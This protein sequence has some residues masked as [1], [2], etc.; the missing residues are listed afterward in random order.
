MFREEE[1]EKAPWGSTAWRW[2][3]NSQGAAFLPAS[4]GHGTPPGVWLSRDH[5]NR[6][7][8]EQG[9]ADEPVAVGTEGCRARPSA[10]LAGGR[11]EAGT[12]R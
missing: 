9:C 1:L 6:S 3:S 12:V 5:G 4:L 7:E 8:A 10:A 11:V 2:L